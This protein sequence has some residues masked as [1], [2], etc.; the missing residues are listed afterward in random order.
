MVNSFGGYETHVLEMALNRNKQKYSKDSIKI[1]DEIIQ[2]EKFN[3]LKYK[4][5]Q[6]NRLK[7]LIK[8]ELLQIGPYQYFN[9]NDMDAIIIFKK[10]LLFLTPDELKTAPYDFYLYLIF[11]DLR[12][13][14]DASMPSK[15]KNLL[16]A[17]FTGILYKLD[18]I[19]KDMISYYYYNFYEI[20]D[21]DVIINHFYNTNRL[22]PSDIQNS[23]GYKKPY[24]NKKNKK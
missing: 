11:F 22:L 17:Y 5:I 6:K 24:L 14:Q 9:Y 10:M 19:N 8:I 23:F 3:K 2:A 13:S 4:I 16:L 20:Y 21:N 7:D 18:L 1:I 15:Y 12:D